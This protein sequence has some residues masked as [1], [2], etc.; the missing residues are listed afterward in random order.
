M[1]SEN[2]R[3][4]EDPPCQGEET[5]SDRDASALGETDAQVARLRG[6]ASDQFGPLYE[7]LAPA[8]HVWAA[9]RIHPNM[10]GR[11]DPEDVVQEVWWRT[12]DAFP[13][14]D[15]GKGAFRT[16]VFRIASNVL[17]NDFRRLRNHGEMPA[18]RNRPQREPL[19]DSLAAQATSISTSAARHELC[20]EII[21]EA[22]GLGDKDRAIFVYCGL[23]GLTALEAS[24]L[25]GLSLDAVFKRWQ[26]LRARLRGTSGWD[27]FLELDAG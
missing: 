16:W 1:L 19:P 20:D 5:L 2:D 3:Q 17:L 14:F 7:R 26:R 8:I 4:P 25:S 15:P 9:L 10:R 18:A 12:M 23:E 6:G 27:R 11:L 24:V 22:A 21:R 13:S